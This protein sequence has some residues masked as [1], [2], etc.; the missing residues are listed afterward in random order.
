MARI[1]LVD[2]HDECR[3]ALNRAL[4]R[5]GH[6]VTQAADGR[7]AVAAL[8]GTPHDLVVT[9]INMPG[10]DGIELI[11]AVGRRW[12]GV[13]IIAVSGGGMLPKELL[14]DNAAVLGAV[15]TLP[16]PVDLGE[17]HAAVDRALA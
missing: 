1:L 11:L 12:P 13:P 9:D 6:E 3:R 16:K 14:L 4:Q 5:M 8:D 17:L 15:T 7:Q 2:D 10:M